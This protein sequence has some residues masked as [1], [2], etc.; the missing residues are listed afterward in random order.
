M[1][2][3]EPYARTFFDAMNTRD[4]ADLDS[5]IDPGVIFDFPGAGAIHGSR[6]MIVFLKILFRKYAR[7]VFTVEEVLADKERACVVW[8]NEGRT[9][10]GAPYRNRGMTFMRFSGGRIVR[11]SDYF[12]DT[13]FTK[14]A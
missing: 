10:E 5:H 2:T 11:L 1:S 7:L 3:T 4:F 14:K 13:S 12:K 6:R 8:A 9:V